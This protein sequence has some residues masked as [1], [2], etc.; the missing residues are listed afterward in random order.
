ME[1]L[2][3]DLEVVERLGAEIGLQ[4]NSRKTE[5]ICPN[6]DATASLRF[7]LPGSHVVDPMKATLLG[8]PIGDV[9]CISDTLRAKTNLLRMMGDRVQLCLPMTPFF[10]SNTPSPS[11]SCCIVSGPPPVSCLPGFRNMTHYSRIS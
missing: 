11:Q 9:S 10:S 1:D 4:L 2:K 5:I 6:T 3:H 8:S 7:S